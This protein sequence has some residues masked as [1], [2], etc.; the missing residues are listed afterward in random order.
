MSY[1]LESLAESMIHRNKNGVPLY[2]FQYQG[3]K[4]ILENIQNGRNTLLADE[5]GLGK[6]VQVLAVLEVLK[7]KSVLIVVPK[8]VALVWTEHALEWSP[9][10]DFEFCLGVWAGSP[11]TIT[12]YE[13]VGKFGKLWGFKNKFS[14][15]VFDEAQM[16]KNAST[17]RYKS[18]MEML[19][20]GTK[21]VI[22]HITGTPIVNYADELYPVIYPLITKMDPETKR[23]RVTDEYPRYW[24]SSESF[25]ARYLDSIKRTRNAREL[26]EVLHEKLM[27]RRLTRDVLPELPKK[28]RQVVDLPL[29]PALEELVR[30]EQKLLKNGKDIQTLMSAESLTNEQWEEIISALQ[31]GYRYPIDK[32][33]RIRHMMALAKL[34][35]AYEY[36]DT[37]LDNNEKLVVFGHH[38]DV[39]D[40]VNEHVR[41]YL[42]NDNASYVIDGHVEFNRRGDIIHKFQHDPEVRVIVCGMKVASLGITLTAACHLIFVEGDWVPSVLSQAEKRVHRIGQD[43]TVLIQHLVVAGSLDATM[44]KRCVYKQ[45]Q[46]DRILDNVR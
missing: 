31:D 44:A 19:S 22:I 26:H 33:A 7:P 28:R 2:N 38:R 43:D 6:T 27:I 46:Q 35:S 23:P 16:L 17:A 1:P 45:R 18:V 41:F 24:Y 10:L 15:I 25:Q 42:K 3:M 36:I 8:N 20:L 30:E 13:T 37:V 32:M 39:L 4:K 5:M 34:E 12:T 11:Y 21:P 9:S 40:L 29:T 14:L